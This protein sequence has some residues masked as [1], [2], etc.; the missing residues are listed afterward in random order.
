MSLYILGPWSP[1]STMTKSSYEL[2][3]LNGVV[4]QAEQLLDLLILLAL[5]LT[6]RSLTASSLTASSLTAPLLEFKVSVADP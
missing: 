6:A 5:L 2:C 4:P 1:R 3:Y